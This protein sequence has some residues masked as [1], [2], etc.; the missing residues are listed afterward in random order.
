VKELASARRTIADLRVFGRGY[1]RNVA[2][3]FFGLIFPVIL[4]LIFGAIFSGNS[5][6]QVTV[7]LQNL[8]RS[9]PPPPFGNISGNLTDA[10]NSTSILSVQMV[11]P[12]Q[13]FTQYLSD[14][15]SSDGII[16]PENFSVNYWL[17]QPINLTVYG[18]PTQTT[19]GII[20]GVV[21][22]VLDYFNLGRFGGSHIIGVDSA[23]VGYQSPKYIDYLIPGL[24]GFSILVS[25]MFSMVNIASEYK[26]T[27]LF[28][29]LSLTPITKFEW[30]ASKILFYIL[31]AAISFLLMVVVGVFVF[32]AHI[33]LTLWLIPF[34][35]LGPMLFCSLGMLVGIATKSVES[36]SVLGNIITFPMMFLSGTFFP[37]SIMPDYLR[38]IAHGLPLFYIIEGLNNI[39]VYGNYTSALADIA[40]IAVVAIIIFVAASKLFRWRED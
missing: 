39:M 26:K 15:S 13:N 36:A 1:L 14:H 21:N 7:Y 29:Q 19:N 35:I 30:L 23:T 8:D 17:E 2:G 27:K 38:S 6:G 28:R 18:N 25:P 11:D 10:L 33:T 34:F 22:G 20:L 37:I 31:L 12:S 5:T 9:I 4:I 40:V 3:L 16:I 32:D 24:I